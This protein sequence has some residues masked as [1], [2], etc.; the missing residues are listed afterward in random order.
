MA[1]VKTIATA[2]STDTVMAISLLPGLISLSNF[3]FYD[4]LLR[5]W[6]S[7]QFCRAGHKV[8]RQIEFSDHPHR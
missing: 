3:G 4:F 7:I 5:I 6:A 1:T 8:S 2:A